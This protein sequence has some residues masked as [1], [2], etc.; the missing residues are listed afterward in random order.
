MRDGDEIEFEGYGEHHPEQEPGKLKFKLMIAHDPAFR[1]TS[2]DLHTEMSI[3]LKDALVGFS[4]KLIHL[5]GVTEIEVNRDG[6][7]QP[8]EV[9]V[10]R[11]RG[12]PLHEFPSTFGD[13]YIKFHILF[14]K[15]VSE[16]QK[17][18]FR[19]LL[20]NT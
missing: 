2:N 1:R 16:E 13:L 9:M 15:R 14:P 11:G 5:D 12:M 7:T 10:L 8:D 18:V 4:R 17:G 20:A 19:K 3:T 6:V